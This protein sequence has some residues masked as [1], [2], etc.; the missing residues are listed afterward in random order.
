MS[1]S[2]PDGHTREIYVAVRG[3]RSHLPLPP[4]AALTETIVLDIGDR[5]RLLQSPAA[6]PPPSLPGGAP[7]AGRP[8]PGHGGAGSPPRHAPGLAV[9]HPTI[10]RHPTRRC[11]WP[12]ALPARREGQSRHINRNSE[13]SR[14]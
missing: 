5:Y 12:G 1:A 11:C 9:L 14:Q 6:P 8:V 13:R 3:E 4:G 2:L 7:Q 10:P